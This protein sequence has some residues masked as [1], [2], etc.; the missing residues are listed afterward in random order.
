MEIKEHLVLL[1]REPR[2]DPLDARQVDGVAKN[3]RAV[4]GLVKVRIGGEDAGHQLA[5]AGL[6]QPL[7]F[8]TVPQRAEIAG[9][10]TGHWSA[11]DEA[12][13]LVALGLGKHLELLERSEVA[14]DGGEPHVE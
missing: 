3:G 13:P 9:L 10:G 6:D 5:S 12:S 2:V 7:G 1:L 14:L 8:R 11:P 4:T